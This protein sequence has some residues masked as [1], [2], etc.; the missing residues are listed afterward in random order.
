MREIKA[1][2]NELVKALEKLTGRTYWLNWACGG[3]CLDLSQ[4]GAS[5]TPRTSKGTQA[6]PIRAMIKGAELALEAQQDGQQ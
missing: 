5:L 2:L 3:V 1:T 6:Q 4:A